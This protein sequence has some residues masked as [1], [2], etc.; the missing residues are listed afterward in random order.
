MF[1]GLS[2]FTLLIGF[3]EF[4]AFVVFF[5]STLVVE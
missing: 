2:Q 3:I 1:I 4:V 5:L